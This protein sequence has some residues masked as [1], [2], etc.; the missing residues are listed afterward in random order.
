MNP[1]EYMEYMRI[2]LALMEADFKITPKEAE[3][4]EEEIFQKLVQNKGQVT[5][6]MLTLKLGGT[7]FDISQQ[8]P[9][10]RDLVKVR[11]QVQ[12]G[13]YW[14]ERREAEEQEY[15]QA[16]WQHKWGKEGTV[17]KQR[18]S[19]TLGQE[20]QTQQGVREWEQA[21]GRLPFD[22]ETT[23]GRQQLAQAV[24]Q[25]W[26]TREAAFGKGTAWEKWQ[27]GQVEEEESE[28]NLQNQIQIEKLIQNIQRKNYETEEEY[29]QD[30]MRVV[31][32]VID[33]A[34]SE[35]YAR[36]LMQQNYAIA[37]RLRGVQE[38]RR[39][40]ES[41]LLAGEWPDW[42]KQYAQERG[43]VV[44]SGRSGYEGFTAFGERTPE[45]KEEML[46][47]GAEQY[48]QYPDL[49]PAWLQAP[50][51]ERLEAGGFK[52]WVQ[53][54]PETRAWY[55]Q[56]TEFLGEEAEYKAETARRKAAPTRRRTPKWATARV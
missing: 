27:H 23:G 56:R 13:Q 25:K 21:M 34:R 28:R 1:E 39:T 37:S 55:E 29:L 53:S 12:V 2:L 44:D 15:A 49:Y 52:P 54:K 3:E 51:T 38:R 10:I 16:K 5:P 14:A 35:T 24:E 19:L 47:R 43:E 45:F 32:T 11:Y 22:V 46:A 48:T 30:K 18:E 20:F 40:G 36:N 7:T 50:L 4:F 42:F 41:Q 6:D 26:M 8:S 9:Y 33:T 17:K 31:G